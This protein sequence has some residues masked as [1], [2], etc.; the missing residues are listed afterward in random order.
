MGEVE[1]AMGGLYAFV[2]ARN[3]GVQ[4]AQGTLCSLN[5]SPSVWTLRSTTLSRQRSHIPGR[6]SLKRLT[7]Q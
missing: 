5:F 6:S 7:E 3:K 1:G 2:E 4:A